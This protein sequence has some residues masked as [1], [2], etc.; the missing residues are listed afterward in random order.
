MIKRVNAGIT[1]RSGLYKRLFDGEIFYTLSG[2]KVHYDEMYIIEGKTPFRFND[3]YLAG[4]AMFY[5]ELL[6]QM[7]VEWYDDITD[8][9]LC[10]VSDDIPSE[11]EYSA[12]ITAY[13]KGAHTPFQTRGHSWVYATPVT[14]DDLLQ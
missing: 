10:W 7:E 9:V 2:S 14:P 12:L 1:N 6:T 8:S 3:T 11:R 4:I 13:R 5:S